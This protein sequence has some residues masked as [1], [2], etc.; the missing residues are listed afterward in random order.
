MMPTARLGRLYGYKGIYSKVY[1]V[2]F[3]NKKIIRIRDVRFHKRNVFDKD[4]E[5][6]AFPKAVFDKE[7]KKLTL[8]TVCFHTMLGSGESPVPRT[9]MTSRS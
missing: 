4:E 2:R 6:E 3:D 9:P 5:E 7:A 1:I 8:R